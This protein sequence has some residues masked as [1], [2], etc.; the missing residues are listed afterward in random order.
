M[1]TA[2]SAARAHMD[3]IERLSGNGNSIEFRQ[4]YILCM[5]RCLGTGIPILDRIAEHDVSDE[6]MEIGTD[7]LTSLALCA[8][9]GIGDSR[10]YLLDASL[11]QSLS[12]QQDQL[13]PD[14]RRHDPPEPTGFVWFGAP[15]LMPHPNGMTQRVDGLSWATLDVTDENGHSEGVDS[16]GNP[17]EAIYVLTWWTHIGEGRG[18]D[19]LSTWITETGP[20]S[21]GVDTYQVMTPWRVAT[22]NHL[23]SHGTNGP[24]RRE[25]GEQALDDLIRFGLE[26]VNTDG[27]GL[28]SLVSAIFGMLTGKLCALDGAGPRDS[29]IRDV[30]PNK[31]AVKRARRT[32]RQPEVRTVSMGA[33][34]RDATPVDPATIGTGTPLA[35]QCYTPGYYRRPRGSQPGAPRTIWVPGFWRGDPSLPVSENSTVYVA[36]AP[37]N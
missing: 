30:E 33:R 2:T 10:T 28:G 5:Q 3:L 35:V 14:A 31:A 8:I 21:A 19:E 20:N 29:I 23:S 18:E 13:D 25:I 24:V 11:A 16:H 4:H 34:Y 6:E 7:I 32:K 17:L 27:P 9:S 36:R 15:L 26:L 12:A 37:R 1:S 22:V